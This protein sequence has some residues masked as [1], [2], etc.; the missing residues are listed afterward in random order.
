VAS[1]PVGKAASRCAFA[2][3]SSAVADDDGGNI[4]ASCVVMCFS[5]SVMTFDDSLASTSGNG[6][7]AL[8]AYSTIF[9][10]F[11][12]ILNPVD[13]ACVQIYLNQ[14]R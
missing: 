11:N 7:S 9:G 1:A 4:S 12:T 14:S 2:D 5:L 13:S 8:R 10:V 3:D 6:F